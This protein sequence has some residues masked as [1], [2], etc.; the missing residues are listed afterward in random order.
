MNQQERMHRPDGCQPER[1]RPDGCQPLICLCGPTGAGKTAAALALA[2]EFPVRIINA[3]SRQV[4][5]DVPIITAQPS[6][7]EQATCAHA[8]YGVLPME[9]PSS[10]GWW[11]EAALAEIELSK[12]NGKNAKGH[13][14]IPLLVGGTGL[15]IRALTDGIVDIPPV[16]D[17]VRESLELEL[18]SLGGEAL[19]ARLAVVDPD[20]ALRVHPKN[21]QRLV[22]ALAVHVVTGK[23]FSWWHSQTPPAPFPH[24]LRIGL[25]LPLHHSGDE[26]TPRL[27]RRIHHM[28]DAGAL[29]E[30]RTAMA[31]CPSKNAPGWSGIGCAEL[32]AHLAGEL[33]LDACIELWIKN[34]RAYAK[35]QLTWFRADKRIHWFCPGE[36]EQIVLLASDWLKSFQENQT[37]LYR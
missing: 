6:Q 22:R 30:A 14:G 18:D 37:T 13:V 15:Y 35:R 24:V 29:N 2:S 12:N 19:H 26:L 28:L 7:E 21:R 33:S 16:P 9:A 32:F 5:R 11:C 17:A 34:T 10:A 3:D 31:L 23:S 20:Y 8:L 4:Y 27:A 1:N 36:E 25:A